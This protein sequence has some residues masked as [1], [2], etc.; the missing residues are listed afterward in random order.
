[1][2]GGVGSAKRV[3][4]MGGTFDPVHIGHL[5][6]AESAREAAGLDR[7]VFVPAGEPPHKA[8][9]ELAPAR[10]RYVMTLLATVGHPSFSVSRIELD[11]QGKSYTVDTLEALHKELG[12]AVELYFILGSDAMAGLSGWHRPQRLFELCRFLVIRRPGWD[13]ARLRESLGGLYDAH[14]DRIQVVDV[15]GVDVSSSEIRARV[16]E[17]RSIRYLVPEM[18]ERYIREHGL[19]GRGQGPVPAA[20]AGEETARAGSSFRPGLVSKDGE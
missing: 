17:G 9:E 5:I 16:R 6:A 7:V 18:V 12:D 4:I 3:G 19:Y 15:P 20:A 8:K 11:R 10:D 13:P 14:R 1:M 2:T